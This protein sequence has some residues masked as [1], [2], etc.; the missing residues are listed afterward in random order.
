MLR[1]LNFLV[2]SAAAQMLL[3]SGAPA[4]NLPWGSPVSKDQ[5]IAVSFRTSAACGASQIV[6]HANITVTTSNIN[7]KATWIALDICP[8][9]NDLPACN[10]G[11]KADQFE[12]STVSKRIQF[13]WVPSSTKNLV[14]DAR[15]W[16]VMTSNVEDMGKSV[17]WYDGVTKFGPSN[18]P[19]NDVRSAFTLSSNMDWVVDEAKDGRTVASVQLV[20][21]SAP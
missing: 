14:P 6:D 1:M 18:D 13:Q 15:Y 10:V 21:R 16:L 20:A 3:D 2:A 5:A 8:T 12:I 4:D 19:K 9:V 17:I 11:S 7:P